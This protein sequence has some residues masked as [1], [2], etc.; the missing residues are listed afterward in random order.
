MEK[1]AL[2]GQ[3]LGGIGLLLLGTGVNWFVSIHEKSEKKK[4]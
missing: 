3:F 1:L 2:L 4:K